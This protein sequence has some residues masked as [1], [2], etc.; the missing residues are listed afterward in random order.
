MSEETEKM[1][2]KEKIQLNKRAFSIW[3]REYPALFVSTGIY[4][5][6]DA[7]F[8]YIILYFSA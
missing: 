6:L 3:Y 5:M 8:P 1:T 4:S 7:V 2:R